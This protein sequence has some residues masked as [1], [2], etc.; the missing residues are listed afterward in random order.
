MFKDEK[1]YPKVSSM[2]VE[3]CRERLLNSRIE[4]HDLNV[5]IR[6]NSSKTKA[7]YEKCD[8]LTVTLGIQNKEIKKLKK[9]LLS[10]QQAV[11]GSVNRL[12]D[13]DFDDR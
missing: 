6:T 3:E 5:R 7:V 9:A 12:V 1:I 8:S 4:I 13:F 10:I 2:E 11:N